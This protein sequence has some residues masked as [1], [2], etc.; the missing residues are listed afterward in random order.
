MGAHHGLRDRA[1]E[2][3]MRC[4]SVVA[5]L[6]LAVLS[7]SCLPGG[8]GGG[9]PGAGSVQF[10]AA[11]SSFGESAGKVTVTVTRTGG[12]LGVASVLFSVA[13][14]TATAGVDYEV[15][16]STGSL[17]WSDGDAAPKTIEIEILGDKLEEA[18]ETILLGLSAPSGAS[19]GSPSSAVLKI[20]D[21]DSSSPAGTIRFDPSAYTFLEG[22]LPIMPP[23]MPNQ[24]FVTRTGGSTGAV[25]VMVVVTGGTA[26]QDVD[27]RL[28]VPGPLAGVVLT[29]ADGETGPRSVI[30]DILDDAL[31]EGKETILLSLTNVTGGAILGDPKSATVT[32]EDDEAAIVG[33][34]S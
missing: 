30:V 32:I 8:G 25:S 16:P 11:A 17:I 15:P 12:S 13:G 29:W 5:L 4:G 3:D 7:P 22:A 14:G 33:P 19:L 28:P 6:V 27:Y 34:G 31:I 23:I 1:E 2:F 26:T 20:I 18:N 10:S 24:I 9:T 21:D